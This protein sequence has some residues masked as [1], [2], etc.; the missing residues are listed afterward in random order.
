MLIPSVSLLHHL[1]LLLRFDPLK[2]HMHACHLCRSKRFLVYYHI[3]L[4]CCHSAVC[5]GGNGGGGDGSINGLASP[6]PEQIQCFT[7]ASTSQ[8]ISIYNDC[9]NVQMDDVSGRHQADQQQWCLVS[10]E[11]G[12]PWHAWVY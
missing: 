3:S 10:P 4:N 11:G 12:S 5:N 7:D 6:T 9:R 8:A 2:W 1:T